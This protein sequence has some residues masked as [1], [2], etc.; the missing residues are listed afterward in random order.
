[1]VLHSLRF[2][3]YGSIWQK[4]EV[5]LYKKYKIAPCQHYS[6]KM[7]AQKAKRTNQKPGFDFFTNQKPGFVHKGE[8]MLVRSR[9][10]PV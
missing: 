1:M 3:A 6:A 5:I 9:L 4:I 8:S 7:V 2:L 10:V